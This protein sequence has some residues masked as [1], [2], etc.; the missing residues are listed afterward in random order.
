MWPI[1]FFRNEKLFTPDCS[2]LLKNYFYCMLFIP[3]NTFT[4]EAFS[5]H[6]LYAHCR[7]P[8]FI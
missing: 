6:Q 7:S 1:S 2:A 4:I 3:E 5:L 8:G